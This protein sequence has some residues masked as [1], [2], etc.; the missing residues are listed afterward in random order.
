MPQWMGIQ[1]IKELHA[2]M[3]QQKHT[4]AIYLRGIKPSGE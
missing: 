1:N 3:P 2:P 4:A